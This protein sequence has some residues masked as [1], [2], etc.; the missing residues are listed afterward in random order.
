MEVALS[1]KQK[2]ILSL[3]TLWS[4]FVILVLFIFSSLSSLNAKFTSS[5]EMERASTHLATTQVLLMD[6]VN[7]RATLTST[8]MDSFENS[9]DKLED[10]C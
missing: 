7:R 6:T 10:Q 1:Q 3:L 9:M 4:G 2:T 8:S 5:G